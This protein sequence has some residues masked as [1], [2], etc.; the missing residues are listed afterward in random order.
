ILL[1]FMLLFVPETPRF[2]LLKGQ[3]KRATE[4]LKWLR[5]ATEVEQIEFEFAKLRNSIETNNRTG[6]SYKKLFSPAVL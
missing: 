1:F 3:T 5:G 4:A 2:L 6:T